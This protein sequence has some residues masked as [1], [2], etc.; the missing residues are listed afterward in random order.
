MDKKQIGDCV[1]AALAL[2]KYAL[3]RTVVNVSHKI[4]SH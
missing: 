1:K 3:N 2:N 4:L